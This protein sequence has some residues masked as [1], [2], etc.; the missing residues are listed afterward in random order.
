MGREEEDSNQ[1]GEGG[2][3]STVSSQQASVCPAKPLSRVTRA[4]SERDSVYHL[5]A[6]HF[7]STSAVTE[8]LSAEVS[9]LLLFPSFLKGWRKCPA[10]GR[11]NKSHRS[12]LPW[13]ISDQ[14]SISQS[15]SGNR[16]K[17]P[18]VSVLTVGLS[19]ADLGNNRP[20][21]MTKIPVSSKS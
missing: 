9:D 16:K 12:W 13:W 8:P 4:G 21:L 18:C 10:C 15:S 5:G 1:L 7:Q 11:G 3:V 17:A 2:S 14:S 20:S 19:L 6:G